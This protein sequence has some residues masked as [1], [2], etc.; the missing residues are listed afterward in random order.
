LYIFLENL[1][2]QTIAFRGLSSGRVEAY[3]RSQNWLTNNVGQGFS[4]RGTSV[5]LCLRSANLYVTSSQL[6]RA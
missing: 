3:L 1:V 5:P 2:G 4:L 6:P